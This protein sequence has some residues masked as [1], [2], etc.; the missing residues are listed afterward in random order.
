MSSL[1]HYMRDATE[2]LDLSGREVTLTN[3]ATLGVIP[4]GM[5]NGTPSVMLVIHDPETKRSFVAEL[6]LKLFLAIAKS[7]E[8]QHG[9]GHGVSPVQPCRP[10]RVVRAE[11]N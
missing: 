10:K 9:D 3:E 1:F 11:G 2:T 5:V 6:S 8:I 7:A 4:D